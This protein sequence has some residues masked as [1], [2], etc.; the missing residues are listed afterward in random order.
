MSILEAEQPVQP[1]DEYSRM[2]TSRIEVERLSAFWWLQVPVGVILQK[3]DE[4]VCYRHRED[5]PQEDDPPF[6]GGAPA[7]DYK[8]H[9]ESL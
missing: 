3:I 5:H 6:L 7:S 4:A 1:G 9:S 2:S 8:S